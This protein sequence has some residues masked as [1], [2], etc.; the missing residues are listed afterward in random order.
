MV[1]ESAV[2]ELSTVNVPIQFSASPDSPGTSL[3]RPRSSAVP[4]C[5]PLVV[6]PPK[7]PLGPAEDRVKG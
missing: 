6:N 7:I 4:P 1:G 5:A 3:G 2:L